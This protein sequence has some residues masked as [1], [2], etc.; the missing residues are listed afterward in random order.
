MH[1]IKNG[2]RRGDTLKKKQPKMK[3]RNKE[4]KAKRGNIKKEIN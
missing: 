1:A 3:T 4:C 2:N